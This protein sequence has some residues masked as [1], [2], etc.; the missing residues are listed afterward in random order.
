MIPWVVLRGLFGRFLSLL[1]E[2]LALVLRVGTRFFLFFCWN[3]WDFVKVCVWYF[4][5]IFKCS[6]ARGSVGFF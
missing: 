2:A 3:I 4:P 1:G 6:L 5:V